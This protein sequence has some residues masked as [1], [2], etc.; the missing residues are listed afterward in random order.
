MASLLFGLAPVGYLLGIMTDSAHVERLLDMYTRSE[1]NRQKQYRMRIPWKRAVQ[2]DSLVPIPE[3][4][5]HRVHMDPHELASFFMQTYLSMFRE[6]EDIS[7]LVQVTK[8]KLVKPLAGDLGFY[9]RLSLVALVASTKRNISTDWHTCVGALVQMIENDQSLM[10]GSNSLQE[11]YMHLHLSGL[12]RSPI[13]EGNPR[14]HRTYYGN[15]RPAGEP[16]VL[17]QQSLPG[18]VHI[19]LVVPRSNLAVFTGRHI[20]QVGTPGLHL[21]VRT[22][23]F[24]NSFYAIDVFF[25]R[26]ESDAIDT[27]KVV[28]DTSGWSGTS[29]MIVTCKV[30]TWGLLV[31]RRQDLR[32]ELAVN[33]SPATHSYIS[34]LGYRMAVFSTTLDSKNV[35]ILTQAPCTKPGAVLRTI[36]ARITESA[37]SLSATVSL[38]RDGTVQSIGITNNF[39]ADSEEGRVL[40]SGGVLEISQISPCVLAVSIGEWKNMSRFIFPFPVDGAASKNCPSIFMDRGQSSYVERPST[41]WLQP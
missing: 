18:T 14:K 32:V 3:S 35:R 9:S 13:L 38:K 39:A 21:S 16:G 41:W 7:I 17:G 4:T 20:E 33:T 24:D 19:A 28:E 11:L 27:A 40:K 1:E 10:V 8:R 6:A 26:F 31:G 29:D 5:S 12:Y 2:G 37:E 25:G 23:A 34:D 30:P 36:P 15:P 22:R